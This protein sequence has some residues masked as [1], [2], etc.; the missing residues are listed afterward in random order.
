MNKQKVWWNMN[1]PQ[2]D[3]AKALEMKKD[4]TVDFKNGQSALNFFA[5]PDNSPWL[6][7]DPRQC[8][9][10]KTWLPLMS[11]EPA[12][13]FTYRHPLEVANSLNRREQ[14]FALERGLRLWIIY[15]MKALQN[16]AGLCRVLS[17]NEAILADPLHE[18]Q[19]ISDELTSKCGVPAPPRKLTQEDVDRFIDPNLQHNKGDKYA[20]KAVIADYDGCQVHEFEGEYDKD[21]DS[22]SYKREHGL[23]MM[24]MKIFCDM[25]SGEAYKKDYEWPTL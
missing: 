4:G 7:K 18:V 15:N 17:S 20:G 12:I 3:A 22:E 24:A 1:I 25:K 5:N 16:S 6:Q 14:D 10:L 23:Y 2:Y 19:R 9:T 21:T 8:I 11:A 13:L